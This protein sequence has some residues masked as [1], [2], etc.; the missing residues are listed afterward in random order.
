MTL[1]VIS[2][3]AMK[4]EISFRGKKLHF[5]N[6]GGLTIRVDDKTWYLFASVDEEVLRFMRVKMGTRNAEEELGQELRRW[7]KKWE[8]TQAQ[9][10][11]VFGIKQAMVARIE[12]GKRRLTE[13]MYLR[14]R[15][16]FR[17]V[18]KRKK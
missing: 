2:F 16:D 5:T 8:Y 18:L 14:I 9:A 12:A 7:R 4:G 1:L 6:W 3:L 11:K 10:G 15:E 17:T 13:E